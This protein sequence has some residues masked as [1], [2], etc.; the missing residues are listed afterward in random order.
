MSEKVKGKTKNGHL[1]CPFFKSG[2]GLL[3]KVWFYCIIEN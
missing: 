3:E 1:K 2:L